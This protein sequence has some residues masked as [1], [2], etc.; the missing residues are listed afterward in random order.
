MFGR[1]WSLVCGS[2]LCVGL[3]VTPSTASES[4]L[5]SFAFP[6]DGQP[7]IV[8]FTTSGLGTA[9]TRF[10]QGAEISLFQATPGSLQYI[11]LTAL[12]DANRTLATMSLND[13]RVSRDFTGFYSTPTDGSGNILFAIRGSCIGGG[14][15]QGLVTIDFFS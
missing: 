13:T 12:Q 4:R 6:C 7:K 9:S 8:T 1:L 2:L 14:Q 5:T 11:I 15:I 10:I 3:L